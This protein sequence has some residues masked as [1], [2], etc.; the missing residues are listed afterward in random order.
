MKKS[1]DSTRS[2]A[3]VRDDP[4]LAPHEAYLKERLEFLERHLRF[5]DRHYGSLLR[6]AQAH[7][8]F[9]FQYDAH[10]QGWWFREY[11]P[12]AYAIS[13]IGD[14]NGWDAA[15]N[16]LSRTEDGTWET[17]LDE[18][19][20]RESLTP[21]SRVKLRIVSDNGSID[22]IPAYIRRVVQDKDTFD[23]AGQFLPES[24]YRWL[25]PEFRLPQDFTP[26]I[27]EA[28]PGMASQDGHVGS[29]SE[30]ARTVL[31]RI[32]KAG[33]NVLQ[34]MAVQE[35]PYYGSFGY[36]VSNFFAPSSRFGTPDD[37]RELIDTAHG[38]GIA[39]VMD[40]VHSHAVKN[41]AE[42]LT[43][44]DGT[45][46]LYFVDGAMGIHPQWDSKLFDYGRIHVQRFLL[47]NLAYWMEEFHF[48]G[49]R[50]DGVTSM[51]YR[52]HGNRAFTCYD[53][54]FNPQTDNAAALYLQSANLLVG[55]MYP[56]ALSIA[57]DMS[58][59]PG[60]C[61]PVKEGGLG[62]GYRLAMGIPDYWI[63]L[64]V[65]RRD[66]DWDVEQIYYALINRRRGEANIAYAESHDQ[67]LVGDKTI[68]FRLMDKNMY[69][70]MSVFTPDP[71]V[72]RGIALHKM[73]RFITL[74]L[75]G[76]GYL[77]FMGNEFGH[78]EWIDFPREGNNWSTA[79][80]RRQ[81]NLPDTDHLKY[82]FLLEF[83]RQMIAFE[84]QIGL[85]RLP[86]PELLHADR[87]NQIL[88]FARGKFVFVF[89]FSPSVSLE[90]YEFFVPKAGSYRTVFSS[91]QAQS[92]GY[93]RVPTD[94][95]FSS[96][97]KTG[98][99]FL[100][101]YIPS[102]M[103]MVLERIEEAPQAATDPTP[104]EPPAQDS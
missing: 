33:Y 39:V 103:C 87:K 79:Y 59:M 71:V 2:L 83:D 104:A 52:H 31:P 82:K 64:L 70:S 96:F 40:L 28:H 23:F 25:H 65:E 13:L 15:A 46:E 20:Y 18:R 62:F 73:I 29:W 101:I 89:S 36:H 9:G 76:E 35:H 84:K 50:F 47:S 80:A 43:Q 97:R 90:G 24:R 63:R 98:G 77:N 5:I 92:G 17:F 44:F 8:Y 60:A 19:T 99:D 21:F 74:A 22:R 48:D 102:R 51:L 12:N 75:G 81:W 68:A 41:R 1:D 86:W 42:G 11:A 53:D 27:Y 100:R 88:V 49:F 14:F 4:W 6:F 93:S 54:Y 10:R 67:A 16:P 56:T 45:R 3:L 66:E 61:R 94:Y 72:D 38:M 30:F 37:L 91:D 95:T 55:Q 69:S 58:G 26:L 78:P 57:E 34:L 7:R 32:A 85:L